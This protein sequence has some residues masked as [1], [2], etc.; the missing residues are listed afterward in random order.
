MMERRIIALMAALLVLLT[1][2]AKPAAPA[3]G[4]PEAPSETDMTAAV[5]ADASAEV[6][7]AMTPPTL[8]PELLPDPQETDVPTE[9][10]APS[11]SADDT[12]APAVPTEAATH[13]QSGDLTEPPIPRAT[14]Y[15]KALDALYDEGI[16]PGGNEAEQ[17]QPIEDNTFAV[18]DVDGDGAEE[19]LISYTSASMAG[20]VFYIYDVRRDGSFY[21]ELSG[22]PA[23]TF[24]TNGTVTEGVSHNQ[25]YAGDFWP[26]TLYTYDPARDAYTVSASVD[27]MDRKYMAEMGVEDEFPEE[28]DTSGS[29]FVYFIDGDIPVD[30]TEYERWYGDWRGDA[31]EKEIPWQDL[32][33]ANIAAI[34]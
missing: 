6:T 19:L 4:S 11:L 14:Y 12:A 29:G 7:E 27:A 31:A 24:Y 8:P 1:G 15:R 16:F 28:A 34:Q 13:A 23:M 33:K 32:T 17:G 3:S 9:M 22:F 20:M 25:G 2:C 5:T 21:A 30:V 26:Y 10:T 18:F